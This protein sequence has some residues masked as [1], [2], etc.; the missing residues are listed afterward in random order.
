M[1]DMIDRLTPEPSL[2]HPGDLSYPVYDLAAVRAAADRVIDLPRDGKLAVAIEGYSVSFAVFEQETSEATRNGVVIAGPK[3]S[4]I[5]DGAGLGG[6][7]RELRHTRWGDEDGY[8]ASP[9][10]SIIAAAF[11]AL[12]EWFDVG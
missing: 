12:E 8:I 7:L 11:K 10:G 5:F 9:P 1:T 3:L 2:F 4:L 6:S